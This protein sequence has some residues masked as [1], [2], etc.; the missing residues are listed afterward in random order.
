[1]KVSCNSDGRMFLEVEDDEDWK[2]LRGITHDALSSDMP[3]SERLASLMTNPEMAGDWQEYV[4]PELEEGFREDLKKVAAAVSNA[5]V[6]AKGEVGLL[7]ISPHDRILWYGALNQAR[8]A[9]ED[10]QCFGA[11]APL[12]PQLLSPQR[13]RPYLRSQFYAAL[14]SL[15]LDLGLG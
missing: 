13:R 9:I 14:Q 7:E 12:D 11:D 1:M 15:L 5:H 8:L 10:C 3:L 4:L 6:A 2:I